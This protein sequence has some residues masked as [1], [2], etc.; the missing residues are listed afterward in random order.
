MMGGLG[1]GG[2][3]ARSLL[4]AASP[5]EVDRTARMR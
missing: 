3:E 5:L 1:E 2:S 4:R